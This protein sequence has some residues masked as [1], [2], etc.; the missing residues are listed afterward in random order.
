[1]KNQ[2]IFNRVVRHLRA[3][4]KAAI[5]K[6]TCCYRVEEDGV[7]LKCA[8]GCLI[9]D[10]K[11]TPAIEGQTASA[12]VFS[13]VYSQILPTFEERSGVK[14]VEQLQLIH[15][16]YSVESWEVKWKEL[17]QEWGLEMPE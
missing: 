9:E 8:V 14:F 13:K 7:V 11:Y 4:G 15:D 2:E 10:S 17:A 6:G 12:L 3:Q 16:F 1:M 5:K